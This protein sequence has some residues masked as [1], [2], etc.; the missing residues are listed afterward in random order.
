MRKAGAP[1][2]PSG[3]ALK[4]FKPLIG[5]SLIVLITLMLRTVLRATLGNGMADRVLG[6]FD[7]RH[8]TANTIDADT[9]DNPYYVAID[10][11]VNPNRLYI[12]DWQNSRVLGFH[13]LAALV[14][15]ADADLVIGQPDLYSAGCNNPNFQVTPSSL[16]FPI[17]V[18]VDSHG[19]LYVADAGNNRVLEYYKPFAAGMAA[20]LPA[21]AVL[22]QGG[23]FFANGCN[24]GAS[25]PNAETLCNPAGVALDSA[26]NLYVVDQTNQRALEYN[27]PVVN[28][29]AANRVLGSSATSPLLCKTRGE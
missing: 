25:Q 21:S 13:S 5:I 29:A 8:K 11:S 24:I 18:A 1:E 12:T 27:T 3:R 10:K 15:G 23:D 19:N 2:R 14:R 4:V 26:D 22:G 16:C 7:F 28:A 17:G 9:L 20:G 6:Q